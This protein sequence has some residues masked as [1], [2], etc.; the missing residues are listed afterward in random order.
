MSLILDALR[1]SE[2]ERQAQ[3]ENYQQTNLPLGVRTEPAAQSQPIFTYL[4]I[5]VFTCIITLT[6]TYQFLL[7]TNTNEVDEQQLNVSSHEPASHTEDKISTLLQ[8]AG[9]TA[10]NPPQKT[11]SKPITLVAPALPAWTATPKVILTTP[12]ASPN[13]NSTPDN[14]TAA[15]NKQASA[16]QPATTI[17]PDKVQAHTELTESKSEPTFL[18]TVPHLKDMPQSLQKQIPSLDYASH[19]YDKNA[20]QRNLII[21]NRSLHEGEW[22]NTQL[23]LKS[24]KPNGAVFE[25]NKQIFHLPLLESWP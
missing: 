10:L 18:H 4:L 22:L 20:D 14:K 6:L 24:I 11:S 17:L 23:M 5:I 8:P 19:W 25:F 15:A 9:H 16:I 2:Q 1:K 3:Q 7:K 13:P 21:N 12:T